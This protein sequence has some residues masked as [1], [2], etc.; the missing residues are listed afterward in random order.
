MPLKD[1]DEDDVDLDDPVEALQTTLHAPVS[2]EKSSTNLRRA[3]P[4]PSGARSRPWLTETYKRN[5]PVL[6]TDAQS[7]P[8][9]EEEDELRIGAFD[10]CVS[11]NNPWRMFLIK[12]LA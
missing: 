7:T 6:H 9:S 8:T 12:I 3:T 11:S 10:V 1:E 2:T 4:G 5:P